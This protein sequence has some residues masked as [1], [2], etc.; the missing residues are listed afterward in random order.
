[1]VSDSISLTTIQK[2]LAEGAPPGRV[3]EPTIRRMWWAALETLQDDILLPSDPAQ[4]LWL[5]AP[6]PALYESRLLSRLNGW[7]WAPDELES[8]QSPQCGLL[9]P[10]RVRSVRKRNYSEIGGYQRLPLRQEDGRDPL[11]LII[12]P[13]V[14]LALALQ[15]K[16]GQRHLLMRSDPETL[17]DLL[18]MLDLRLDSEDPEHALQLRQALANLGPLQSNP[19][20]G[21]LFWPRLAERLA[22][23]APSLT[24]QSLP[25]E[26]PDAKSSKETNQGSN[27][28]LTLLEA[29]THEV[30]TPLATI[31]TLIHTLLRRRDLPD[32]VVSRLEQINAECTEQI[33]RFGLIFYAAELQRQPPDASLLAHTDLGAMLTMLCPAWSHQLE[34]RG[35]KLQLDI[36]PDLPEVLSDPGRLEPMLGGLIDRTSRGLPAGNN[37]SMTLRPAGSR[38]KLQILSQI[39]NTEEQK[40][41]DKNQNAD[42]GP[43][44]S[45]DP[46]TGSLQLSQAATQRMLASLGGLLTKRRDKGLTVFFPIAE[47][48]N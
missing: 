46:N 22:G 20:L 42:L 44:L 19:E 14:Q 15:G 29:L 30:R 17:S 2:R 18:K 40:A 26:S 36:T 31:R 43:V 47:E 45:W 6:L 32:V 9:L 8:L 12:T 7:V 16:P 37:L 13:D 3:D 10:S 1:M 35:I 24:L 5:A 21:K 34:R 4:G 48:N 23:L 25:E 39:P 11:L 41:T 27:A 33:D 28:E 38:L